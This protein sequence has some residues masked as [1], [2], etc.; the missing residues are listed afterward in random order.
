MSTYI[1]D[2]IDTATKEQI[3]EYLNSFGAVVLKNFEVFEN[4]YHVESELEPPA[5]NIVEQYI[6]DDLHTIKLLTTTVISDQNFGKIMLDGSVPIITIENDDKNWWK[7]Y[8]LVEPDLDATKYLTNRRGLGSIIYV[9]DSGID[10]THP[11]FEDADIHNLFSFND[12]FTDNKGHGTALASVMIGKTCGMTNA[13]VKSVK[14]FDAG[15]STKQSDILSA[16]NAIYQDRQTSQAEHYI[17]NA[18]WAIDK[19]SY[20]E[21]K[22]RQLMSYGIFF[23]VAAGNNGTPIGDVTPA[24]MPEVLTIGSYNN[25]LKPSNFSDYTGVSSVSYTSGS[26]N[27]GELDGFAPG[28]MIWAATLDGG[29]NYTAG[30]SM[31][32][33]I[34]SAALAY[35]FSL[36]YILPIEYTDTG[37]ALPTKYSNDNFYQY[38][39]KV[40]LGRRDLLDLSDPKYATSNNQVTTFLDKRTSFDGERVP[41]IVTALKS[42]ENSKIT[43]QLFN[44][45]AIKQLEILSD[46]PNET[47]FITSVGKMFGV[48]P[49]INDP[50]ARYEVI[51][52]PLKIIYI[53][54][55]V[56]TEDFTLAVVRDDF[57]YDTEM[58]DDPKL[59][60]VLNAA[61]YCISYEC[62]TSCI[63]TCYPLLCAAYLNWGG[64]PKGWYYC[65]CEDY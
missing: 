6:R 18:S 27:H 13:T 50:S 14:I 61:G 46:F 51:T 65:Q 20:I 33:A 58:G 56:E 37:F 40:G 64:C 36:G 52:I 5:S 55:T 48:T 3:D 7:Y 21:D 38:H 30:T 24:S 9:L 31:S 28:E 2:F 43:L 4:V 34:Q 26:S 39:R 53:D 1:L 16:L 23:V 49:S 60:Y 19:N 32:A 54:N 10:I 15:V 42:N 29:Y 11:E 22:I 47:F 44:P 63:D 17:V 45:R 41:T 57:N 25:Q 8:S 62:G 35:N 12:D 59:E